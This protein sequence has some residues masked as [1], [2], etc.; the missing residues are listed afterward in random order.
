MI[1]WF[2]MLILCSAAVVAVSV[3]LIRGVGADGAASEESAVYQD[4]LNEVDRD[5]AAG[6]IN[7]PEAATA[8]AEIERR[9]LAAQQKR[10][11][12][13][14]TFSIGA[15]GGLHRGGCAG[16]RWRCFALRLYG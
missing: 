10:F 5:L 8:K 1:L 3:P 16:D 15:H 7:A 9:L 11:A 13:K 2:L 14:T 4:Q 6:T 12:G